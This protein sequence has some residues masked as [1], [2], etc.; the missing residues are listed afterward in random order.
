MVTI[1]VD[2]HIS[3]HQALALDAVGTILGQW[4]GPNTPDD[5]H[6]LLAWA[7]AF[8]GPR[9]WGIAGAWHYGRGLPQLL[10]AHGETI[11]AVNPRWTADH[12]QRARK[13]GKSDRLDAHADVKL[14]RD[15]DAPLPQV[16]AEDE[17][18]VLDLL[19]TEREAA[20]SEATRLRNQLHQQLL[21]LNPTYASQLPS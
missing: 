3:I 13:P 16:T 21:Q 15:A 11:S 20:L 10:V 9:Q 4:R 7:Q 18:A 14:V 12:R 19:V 17:A 6:R 1:G 2:A 8:P 5:W